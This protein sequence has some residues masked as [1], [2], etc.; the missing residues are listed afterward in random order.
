MQYHNHPAIRTSRLAF[1]S[2][3]F[4]KTLRYTMKNTVCFLGLVALLLAFSCRTSTSVS[5]DELIAQAEDFI[6]T[7]HQSSAQS[8]IDI[9]LGSMAATSVYMGTDASE[10]WEKDAFS[11]FS[12][13]WFAKGKGWAFAKISRHIYVADQGN[14]VWWDELLDTKLGVCRGSGVMQHKQG[15]WQIEQYVLSPTVPNELMDSVVSMKREQDAKVIKYEDVR[16]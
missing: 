10:R 8:N 1:I 7:W 2:S 11:D 9:Y 16:M 5:N 4:V 15:K 3:G 14:I 13:P 6:I 12:K